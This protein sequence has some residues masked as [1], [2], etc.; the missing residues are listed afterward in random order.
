MLK[1]SV[2]A[3]FNWIIL[4]YDKKI[5]KKAYIQIKVS[6]I[7]IM[8]MIVIYAKIMLKITVKK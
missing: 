5:A 8:E 6:H 4:L 2:I 7:Y 1:Y 3:F